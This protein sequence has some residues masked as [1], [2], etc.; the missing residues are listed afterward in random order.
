MKE[1][2]NILDYIVSYIKNNKQILWVLY[3]PAYFAF[4]TYLE[5]RDN[6]T[7]HLIHSKID[8]KIPFIKEFIIPYYLWFAY[9]AIAVVLFYIYDIENFKKLAV[10]LATGMT[11]FLVVSYVYPNVLNLRPGVISG[12]GIIDKMVK[13]IYN[14]DTP[15]N[16]FP[17]IHVYNSI[18]VYVAIFK[19][20]FRNKY[21]ALNVLCFVLSVLIIM[22]TVFLKQHSIVDVVGAF[23]MAAV[24]YIPVYV[25][26]A[27]K[28]TNINSIKTLENSQE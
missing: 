20:D 11:M 7:F 9:I 12:N 22:S 2:K 16:V 18:V 26:N 4:F 10:Y 28:V 19:S 14:N 3:V 23:L 8:D 15:T 1:R 24:F 5:N 6:V 21:K 27:E 25:I 17:S 13:G